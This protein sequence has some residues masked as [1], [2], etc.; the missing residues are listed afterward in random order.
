MAFD[1][2][3]DKRTIRPAPAPEPEAEQAARRQQAAVLAHDFNNLLNVILAANEALTARLP[4]GSDDGELARIGLESAEKGGVMLRRLMELSQAA[5]PMADEIDCAGAMIG[6]A[7]LANVS[8]AAGVTCVA[9]AM[10]EPLVCLADRAGLDSALLN[11]CVNAGHALPS[12]GAVRLEAAAED[13][14]GEAARGLRVTPGR[15]VALSVADRGVG[16]SPAVLARAGD[17]WF[18]TRAGRG[19]TG[20]GLSGV[21][22]FCRAAGGAL[23]LVSTEGRGTTATLLLP[24]A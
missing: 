21:A 3:A 9:M 11:L 22:A 6:V 1:G 14:D 5:Q 18:T 2:V 20:L 24:R 16:M 8:T 19:G 12:G 7:R 23:R 4:E 17:A 10:P 13:L 15:Y